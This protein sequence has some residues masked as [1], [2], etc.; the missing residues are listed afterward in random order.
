MSG[1]CVHSGTNNLTGNLKMNNGIPGYLVFLPFLGY[2]LGGAKH[3][4]AIHMPSM[5]IFCFLQFV[6]LLHCFFSGISYASQL[7]DFR[8]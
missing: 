4:K 5:C 7:T 1:N 2:F 8:R 3:D 6:L